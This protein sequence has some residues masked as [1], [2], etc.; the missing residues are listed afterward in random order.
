MLYKAAPARRPAGRLL[1]A[2]ATDDTQLL[3]QALEEGADPG[4][5]VH[6]VHN[7]FMVAAGCGS[8]RVLRALYT[9]MPPGVL[10][11]ISGEDQDYKQWPL[12]LAVRERHP[13][14][15]AQ[16]LDWGAVC[17]CYVQNQAED[18]SKYHAVGTH[19]LH[20]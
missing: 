5:P 1:H 13:E 19:V 14:V 16:L 8:L 6:H 3:Q 10:N 18:E 17:C 12:Y 9:V 7:V 20:E 15:V 11:D 2:A 4:E